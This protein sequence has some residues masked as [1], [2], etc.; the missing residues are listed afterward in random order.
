[1]VMKPL[2]PCRHPGC[3]EL[4]RDGYCPAH[5]PKK[6]DRGESAQWH[7]M[8]T[9]PIWKQLRADQLLR[10]PWCADCAKEFPPGDPRRR[11]RA[12]VVD[13]KIPHRGN[14][15]LFVDPNNHQSL[16]ERHHNAKT[17]REVHERRRESSDK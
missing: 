9:L 4:T 12:T 17:A 14:W 2:R 7:W 10:E 3:T 15:R 13:H 1:M 6:A 11:T 5:R 16:C 8:Y